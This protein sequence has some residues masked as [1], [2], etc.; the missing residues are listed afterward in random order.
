MSVK[1]N[2]YRDKAV[3]PHCGKIMVPRLCTYRGYP[4]A[5]FCPFCGGIYKDFSTTD[6]YVPYI[7]G[8]IL[9]TALVYCL[10]YM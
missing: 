6:K 2:H 1:T 10:Y 3:C 5:S 4:T 8:T 9:V 7:V